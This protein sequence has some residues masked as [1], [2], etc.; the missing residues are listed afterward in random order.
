MPER[1][2]HVP[3]LVTDPHTSEN[4][5]NLLIAAKRLELENNLAEPM[6]RLLR[7]GLLLKLVS[8]VSLAEAIPATSATLFIAYF[9]V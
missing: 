8:L 2:K 4:N 6:V 3:N 1:L 5:Q 9:A 7:A